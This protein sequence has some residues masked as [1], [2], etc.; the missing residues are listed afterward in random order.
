M[1]VLPSIF[2]W[3]PIVVFIC[4]TLALRGARYHYTAVLVYYFTP[5]LCRSGYEYRWESHMLTLVII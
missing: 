5:V 2:S 3:H 1:Y 4:L